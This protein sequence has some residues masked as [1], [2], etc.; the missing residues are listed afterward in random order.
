MKNKSTVSF[1][2][3]IILI[4]FA[5]ELLKNYLLKINITSYSSHLL[6]GTAINI[7][8]SIASYKFI[9][10][11]QLGTLIGLNKKNLKRV[12]LL[13]FP[14][15]YMVLLNLLFMDDV[16]VNLF[17]P[18]SIYLALYTI[19]IGFAEEL[20]IRGAIQSF[21]VKKGGDNKKCTI[22]AIVIAS[23]FFGLLHLLNFNKG[24]YGEISQV[25]FATFIGIL[26]GTLL[27]IT[28]RIYPLIII[29]TLIDFAAKL[30]GVGVPFKA[31]TSNPM[32]VQSAIITTALVLPC[33]IYALILIKKNSLTTTD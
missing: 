15:L 25:F 33:L 20:S 19:S 5:R 6:L 1:G 14:L 27:V 32:D 2:L 23:L 3:F 26:F 16:N 17:I 4:V 12:G 10:K 30:D 29:H 8:I 22:K 13:V 24:L 21:L 18:N 7:I 11:H 31:N 9:K 28:K